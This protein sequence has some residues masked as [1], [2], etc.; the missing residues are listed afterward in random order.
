MSSPASNP[1][2][3]KF[4]N[5]PENIVRELLDG[6]VKSHGDLIQLVGNDLVI[7]KKPKA[8]GKV[9]LRLAGFRKRRPCG[10]MIRRKQFRR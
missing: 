6:L 3:K 9:N 7:R 5:K 2:M 8:K 10:P 1:I 4:I